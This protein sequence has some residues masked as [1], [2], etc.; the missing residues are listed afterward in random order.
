[1]VAWKAAGRRWNAAF[2]LWQVVGR[3][4]LHCQMLAKLNGSP[5]ADVT[6]KCGTSAPFSQHAS[7]F[8]REDG[9]RGTSGRPAA[10]F[11]LVGLRNARPVAI[12]IPAHV[13]APRSRVP[14]SRLRRRD[15][16]GRRG[17][18]RIGALW[19]HLAETIAARHVLVDPIAVD[20]GKDP[21]DVQK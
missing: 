16:R 10:R 21:I 1:M 20:V 13:E 4:V 3:G 18:N 14:F 15:G 7:P 8:E 2:W 5:S 11:D 9:R 12:Q 6:L 19:F 17:R